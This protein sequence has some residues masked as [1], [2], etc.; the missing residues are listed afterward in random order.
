M[1]SSSCPF[2]RLV[3]DPFVLLRQQDGPPSLCDTD[4]V[5]FRLLILCSYCISVYGRCGQ[6]SSWPTAYW[7]LPTV[8]TRPILFTIDSPSSSL[9][10]LQVKAG[11][12]FD[13]TR[14]Y[15]QQLRADLSS[16]LLTG[17]TQQGNRY[18]MMFQRMR[19]ETLS[20]IGIHGGVL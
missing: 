16:S 14:L 4:P 17:L 11:L 20:I 3:A 18:D 12:R 6:W 8:P 5:P 15:Q 10:L 2:S 9:E 7:F 13:W 1:T 19:M